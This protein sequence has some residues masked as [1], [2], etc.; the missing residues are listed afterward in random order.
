MHLLKA[1]VSLILGLIGGAIGCWMMFILMLPQNR[2]VGVVNITGIINQ[3]VKLQAQQNLPATQ[4]KAH[5][6][7]F[8]HRLEISLHQIAHEQ[9]VVLL[10]SEAVIAGAK[11]YTPQ[12][13]KMLN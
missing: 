10:P 8:G 6:Q 12:L 5:V 4:V 3:F 11:D 9:H 13:Q 1:N 2:G 7:S